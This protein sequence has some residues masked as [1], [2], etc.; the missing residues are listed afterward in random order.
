MEKQFG[1][2][3]N[4]VIN[5]R[6]F[7]SSISGLGTRNADLDIN[8]LVEPLPINSTM[9]VVR[10]MSDISLAKLARERLSFDEYQEFSKEGYI[11]IKNTRL[12]ISLS[13][14]SRF[15]LSYSLRHS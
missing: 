2:Y 9:E 8:M 1:S 13:R 14:S 6:L 10:E 7:G 5:V 3:I 15:S 4:A 12:T 11:L